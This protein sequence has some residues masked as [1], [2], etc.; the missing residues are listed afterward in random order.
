MDKDALRALHADVRD[1]KES[2]LEL[3]KQSAV[4]ATKFEHQEDKFNKLEEKVKPL[5]ELYTTSIKNTKIAI[6]AGALLGSIL[7]ILKVIKI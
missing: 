3:V 7:T 5:E 1:I 2:V 6:G 4:L